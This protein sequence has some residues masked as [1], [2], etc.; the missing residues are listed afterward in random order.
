MGSFSLHAAR[1]GWRPR[2]AR[3]PRLPG[4]LRSRIRLA[5]DL[6]PLLALLTASTPGC[7]NVKLAYPLMDLLI[8]RQ[9][10]PFLK[11]QRTQKLAEVEIERFVE[12]HTRE[13]LPRYAA[14]LRGAASR[15]EADQ[16]DQAAVARLVRRGSGSFTG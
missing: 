11:D 9:V 3:S 16:L 13:I 4:V 8:E 2:R 15:L 5:L 12:W 10:Q 7:S 6:A 1:A 14:L